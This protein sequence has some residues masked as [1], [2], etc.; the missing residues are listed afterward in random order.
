MQYKMLINGQW[1][2][3]RSGK[4]W[5]VINPATE[6]AI[7]TVP[8]G[9]DQDAHAA[10]NAAHGVQPKWAAMTAY[11]RGA[12][13]Q[14]TADL[15]RARLDELAPIMTRECGKPLAESRAEWNGTANYLEW[16]GEEGKRAYG[17]VIPARTP[18][19]RLLSLPTPIGVVATITAWNFP[20]VLPARKWG[21]ALAAGC[22]VVGRP[23]E[24]TPLSAMALAN[25][26]V[27]AGLL[28]GVLNLVNGDPESIG[29]AFMQSPLVEKI[30]FTGSQRVGRILMRGAADGLKRL[31]LEL[32]GSAPVLVF[33]DVDVEAAAK[34]SVQAK[35]RNN[36]QVC[37]SPA[38][39]YV[40]RNVFEDFLD[41][42]QSLAGGL[43]VGDGLKEGVNTG[44][45]VNAV[46]RERVEAFV[47]D[48]VGK[49]A[50]VVTGGGRPAN[51]TQGYF[52]QPTVLTNVTPE[53]RVSCDEVFGPVMPVSP[54]DTLEDGLRMA[55]DT[56]YG[57]AAYVH[58]RNLTTAIKAYEGLKFGIV[59]VN[60]MVV[61]TAEAPFGGM[62]QS[63][64]GREGGEEGL[65]EYLEAKFVSMVP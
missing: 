51:L 29:E 46:G 35:F 65:E 22:T 3:A 28:P 1:V 6:E 16:F 23:S 45:M 32:G 36:G 44:P 21:A 19:K 57:L 49:G 8:F 38:R 62:K 25:L 61:A 9:N 64:H 31:H 30:S 20:A 34:L 59:G 40:H 56:T 26:F 24:L 33:D 37:I 55:N 43:V 4:T 41:I 39:F 15:I 63:G 53:M 10:I 54:F 12:I 11:E 27:E 14:K 52:Y 48:A 13:L 2:D 17:R 58:T 60:D 42:S 7:V 47:Q 18:G 5:D 50:R